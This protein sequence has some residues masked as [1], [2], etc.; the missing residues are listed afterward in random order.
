[1]FCCPLC[2]DLRTVHY[3][4]KRVVEGK[5]CWAGRKEIKR[6]EQLGQHCASLSL[7]FYYPF[8]MSMNYPL[9]SLPSSLSTWSVSIAR[10]DV[11]WT[12]PASQF[13]ISQSLFVRP[14]AKH[15]RVG[16]RYRLTEIR[17][18]NIQQ[19]GAMSNWS[20]LFTDLVQWRP[21]N[22]WW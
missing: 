13:G 4:S 18:L 22:G 12:E 10:L 17:Y 14:E 8:L 1:M 19:V 3:H 21:R 2:R 5:W 7:H 11:S 9:L 15:S 6:L 16:K 20:S